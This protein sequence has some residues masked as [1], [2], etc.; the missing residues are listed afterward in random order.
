VANNSVGNPC[1]LPLVLAGRPVGEWNR[2]RIPMTGSRVSVWVNDQMTVDH[3][4]LENFYDRK[5]PI[6]P[7]G[8]IELQTH[9]GE[10]RWRNLLLR[11]IGSDEAD[12]ILA[13]HGEDAGFKSIFNGKDMEGWAG[14][15][16]NYEV[17]N[18]AIQC[19]P[20]KGGTPYYN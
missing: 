18:G 19:K 13:S 14:P 7:K 16:E 6:P 9:G 1:K 15:V 4:I 3:A 17:V 11:E 2:L 12:K 8:P 10:I 5:T 20:H